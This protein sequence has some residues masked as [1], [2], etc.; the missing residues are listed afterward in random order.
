MKSRRLLA[1]VWML[2]FSLRAGA[3]ETKVS[4]STEIAPIL[5]AKCQ[6]CHNPEKAKGGYRV[7]SFE[8]FMKGGDSREAAVIPGEPGKSKLYQLITATDPDDRMPQKDDPLSKAQIALFEQ[9]IKEGARYDRAQQRELLASFVPRTDKAKTP[10][11]YSHPMPILSLAFNRNGSELAVG[12]YGELTFWDPAKGTLLRRIGDF[13]PRIQGVVYGPDGNSIAICGGSP[14]ISGELVLTEPFGAAKRA[15]AQSSD[16][17]L[18][19]RFSPDGKRLATAGSDNSI[20]LYNVQTGREE[21]VILQH[22][23]WVNAIAFSNN[24]KL[25]AS[26]SRDRSCRVFDAL[27]GELDATYTGHDGPASAVV[28]ASNDKNVCSAGRDR[29]IHIWDVKEGKKTN[30]ITGAEGEILKLVALGED[31]FSCGVDK[32]ARRYGKTSEK[33]VTYSGHDDWVYAI[34]ID[35]AHGRIATGA[36][37]GEVRLWELESGKLIN[38]FIAAPGLETADAVR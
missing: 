31:L 24:G 22:A 4:F 1:A 25:L 17:V 32:I 16:V 21:L 18:D 19:V 26:A 33:K 9:W 28:F 36:F 10:K 34:A 5:V 15:I 14:G 37:D 23:D 6:V 8:R 35:G 13:P 20:R 11:S 38:A 29:K 30:E 12:G 2:L 27:T 3:G 7:E